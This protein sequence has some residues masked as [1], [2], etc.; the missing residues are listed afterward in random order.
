M[1][2]AHRNRTR[3]RAE[4]LHSRL[5]PSFLTYSSL[6]DAVV[7]TAANGESNALTITSGSGSVS[8]TDT[9]ISTITIDLTYYSSFS[10]SGNSY[11]FTGSFSGVY[12]DAGDQ[13]DVVDGSALSSSVWLH[14]YSRA[15]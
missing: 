13:A 10:G 8:F 6:I 2:P 12:V 14:A 4:E 15:G 9:G 11:T 7:Y 5:N 3:L 1:R